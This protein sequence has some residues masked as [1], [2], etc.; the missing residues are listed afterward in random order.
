MYR[1]EF[2]DSTSLSDGKVVLVY[3]GYQNTPSPSVYYQK[4]ILFGSN[5]SQITLPTIINSNASSLGLIR[6]QGLSNGKF[7]IWANSTLYIYSSSG[8]QLTSIATT[9]SVDTNRPINMA[10]LSGG[11]FAVVTMDNANSLVQLFVYDDGLN[12]L[13]GP[14]TVIAGNLYPSVVTTIGNVIYVFYSSTAGTVNRILEYVETSTNTWTV[15][16]GANTLSQSGKPCAA[17][18]NSF[19][20]GSLLFTY[21]D[22]SSTVYAYQ[23]NVDGSYFAALTGSGMTSLSGNASS[24]QFNSGITSNGTVIMAYNP[25]STATTQMQIGYAWAGYNGAVNTVN[26]TGTYPSD[27]SRPTISGFQGERVMVAYVSR[28]TTFARDSMAVA[29][30]NMGNFQGT[31]PIVAGSSV[32]NASVLLNTSTG[33]RLVGVAT[34]TAPAG[35]TGTVVIN[36][37]ATL[38]ST[39]QSIASPGQAFDFSGP[40]NLQGN[41]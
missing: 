41:V 6:V 20:N 38:G 31:Q 9:Y 4:F 23:S 3:S 39:Y 28:D 27:G 40:V 34:S 21:W 33:Y 32:S 29:V 2:T 19:N 30:F 22:S 15:T 10:A 35:G 26:V 17:K 18:A 16:G 36:G 5:G 11:R 13:F 7:V 24:S 1:I 37:S 8:V 12:I 25:T 14:T